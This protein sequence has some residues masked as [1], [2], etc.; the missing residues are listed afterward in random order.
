MKETTFRNKFLNAAKWSFITEAAARIVSPLTYMILARMIAPEAFGVL[1]SVTL[2]VSFAEMFA[3]A[4]F[5]KY[6]IQH[7]FND[8][9]EQHRHATVAFWTNLAIAALSWL[10]IAIFCD[11]IAVLVGS[12]GLGQVLAVA[13][14]E[15]PLTAFSSIQMAVYRR[16]FNFK[17]LFFVRMVSVCLPF[18]VT[19]PLAYWGLSYWSLIIASVLMQIANAVILTLHSRWKPRFFYELAILK[20]MLSFSIWSLIESISIWLTSWAD[21]FIISTLLNQYYLG[22]Y[23]TSTTMVNALMSLV[24]ASTVPV[25]FSA[26]SRL[27]NHPQKFNQLYF[28]TQRFVSIFIFPLGIGV[29]C[30]RDLA[31]RILL[32]SKW[33]EASLIIGLWAFTSAIV[34]VFGYFCSEVYRAKGKPNLSVLVQLSHV[35]VLVP[36]CLLS[37]KYGFW[38]LVHSRAWIRLELVLVH[39]IVMK[40]ALG[41][42]IKKTITNVMPTGL[43]ALSMG[44]LATIL[45]QLGSNFMWLL[46]SILICIMYYFGIL[47]LFPSMQKDI[48]E[49]MKRLKRRLLRPA[50]ITEPDKSQHLSMPNE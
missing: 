12:P 49:L 5:H 44:V 9:E 46:I 33:K 4:G 36:V 41:I 1:A 34:I 31:T 45:L 8:E 11:K 29:Y 50:Y 37:L 16:S 38:T 32:G 14:I 10:L 7:D 47:Y 20:E 22:I 30:Y 28:K 39:F 21:I 42:P 6:L 23:K 25:L 19:I 15:L 35:L 2:I 3:D 26:L 43:S 48:K 13:A 40:Y 18:L 27:Q 24:T 17:T